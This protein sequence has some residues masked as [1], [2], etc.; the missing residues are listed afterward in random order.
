MS[1][2]QTTPTFLQIYKILSTFSLLKPREL[3]NCSIFYTK[4]PKS[5]ITVSELKDIYSSEKNKTSVIDDIK[6]RLKLVL[7]KNDPDFRDSVI[8]N[9]EEYSLAALLDCLTFFT[10]GSVC[11]DLQPYTKCHRCRDVLFLTNENDSSTD[12][13]SLAHH[14]IVVGKFV[15]SLELFYNKHKESN[16]VFD[17]VLNDVSQNYVFYFLCEEHTLDVLAYISKKYLSVRMRQYSQTLKTKQK[18]E[19]FLPKN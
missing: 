14:N 5:L 6:N 10:I 1:V 13:S 4:P 17:L 8:A 18:G 16:N 11:T 7:N 3:G 15:K 19:M 12:S 2:L 9:E